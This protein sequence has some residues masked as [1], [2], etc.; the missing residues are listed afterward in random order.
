MSIWVLCLPGQCS[1]AI[2]S[3]PLPPEHLP[4][5]VCPGTRT[6]NPN[7]PADRTYFWVQMSWWRWR[8]FCPSFLEPVV[9]DVLI[10]EFPTRPTSGSK[11][12]TTGAH[13]IYVS[14]VV[15]N[16]ISCWTHHGSQLTSDIK[17]QWVNLDILFCERWAH[18]VPRT[19]NYG[20]SVPE[21]ATAV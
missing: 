15:P 21:D 14:T 1:E 19:S 3:P 11:V 6:E 7:L 16:W 20:V 10:F 5:V 12:V 2:L 4:R 17:S 13:F 9:S 18:L 8:T